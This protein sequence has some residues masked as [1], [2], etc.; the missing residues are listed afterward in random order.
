MKKL[1]R[2]CLPQITP[3]FVISILALVVALAGTAYG[4]P[5]VTHPAT[6]IYCIRRRLAGTGPTP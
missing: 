5:T 2:L 4:A 1:G 6:G 3:S